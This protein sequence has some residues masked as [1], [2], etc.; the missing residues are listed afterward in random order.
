MVNVHASLLPRYRG[1]A[2]VHRAI[3]AGDT[4]TGVT[5]MRVV[6]ALDAG[7]MLAKVSRAIG[8]NDTSDEVERDLASK[9]AALLVVTIDALTEG[10][11]QEIPQA[12]ADATYAHRLTKDD[13]LVDWNRPAEAIHNQIRGFC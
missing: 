2:P 11:A 1:A 13:G 4:E 8:P 7:P 3:I 6:K 12:D 9:G 10:R 5:I